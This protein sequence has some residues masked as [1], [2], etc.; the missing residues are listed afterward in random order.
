MFHSKVPG[1]VNHVGDDWMADVGCIFDGHMTCCAKKHEN[2]KS[3]DRE[4]LV[5]PLLGLFFDLYT[6]KQSNTLNNEAR[7]AW[8]FIE[9][10]VDKVFPAE[11]DFV[12]ASKGNDQILKKTLFGDMIE[13]AARFVDKDLETAVQMSSGAGDGNQTTKYA[14]AAHDNS[15]QQLH[16]MATASPKEIFIAEV[17]G[18]HLSSMQAEI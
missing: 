5:N 15:Q 16:S 9:N 4:G 10:Q 1:E 18:Q 2:T 13:R 8:E 11:F 12:I 6:K 3:C 17:Q 7:T 14:V